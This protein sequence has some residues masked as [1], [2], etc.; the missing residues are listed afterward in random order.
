M[1]GGK[2]KAAPGEIKRRGRPK[3]AGSAYLQETSDL[4]LAA[5][6]SEK[7]ESQNEQIQGRNSGFILY[8]QA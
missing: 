8:F 4:P 7:Y 5:E 3:R 2:K 6:G 1:Q